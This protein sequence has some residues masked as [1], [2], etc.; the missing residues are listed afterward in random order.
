MINRKVYKSKIC[1]FG[2]TFRNFE[3]RLHGLPEGNL[4]KYLDVF[5]GLKEPTRTVLGYTMDIATILDN[6]QLNRD[7]VVFGGYAVLSHLMSE[8]GEEAAKL[9]RGSSDIDMAGTQKVRAL[10]RNFYKVKSDMPSPNLADK[11]TLLLIENGENECKVDFYEGDIKEKFPDPEIN[12]H[13]GVPLRVA[14]PLNL[15]KGKLYTPQE[16]QLHAIDILKMLSV[17]ERRGC[18]PADIVR[19]FLPD[20]KPEL[21]KRVN[22]ARII[23]DAQ[24]LDF[25]PSGD[26]TETL[27]TLLRKS[28][29]IRGSRRLD[30]N[31]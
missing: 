1:R 5:S 16:Q 6:S 13:F 30:L 15:I 24:R 25:T 3:A 8:L 26:F 14:S 22:A 20:E 9:W 2:M 19:Y 10:M 31:L 12:T 28:R 7:Y 21:A 11:R 18:Q 4:A 29:P 27:E 17:L 23:A